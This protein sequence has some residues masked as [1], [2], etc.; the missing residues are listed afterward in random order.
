MARNRKKQAA[1]VRFG[2]AVKLLLLC[3]LIG[4]F[5]IGYVGQKNQLYFLSSQF[6]ELERTL[7]RLQRENAVRS[8]TLDSLQSLSEL[9]IRIRK[10]GLGLVPPQPDQV[11]RLSEESQELRLIKG[12]S[13]YV[14]SVAQAASVP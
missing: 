11:I 8:R 3:L 13:A 10:M 6:K 2:P 9:E 5:G 12:D 14:R 7:T 4:V 1:T